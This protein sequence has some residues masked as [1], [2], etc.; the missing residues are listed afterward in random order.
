VRRYYERV[1]GLAFSGTAKDTFVL[2]SGNVMSAFFGFVFTLFVAR[3]LSVADFGVFSAATNLVIILISLTDL[4][5]STGIVNFV[6]QKRGEGDSKGVN[7][8]IKAS[9]VIKVAST[10]FL[11]LLVVAFAGFISPKFLATGDVTV[12]FWV[13]LISVSFA[14]P[15]LLPSVLQA[16]RRFLP[17]VIAD[18]LLYFSRLLFALGFMY[19]AHLTI[20]NS[21]LTFALAGIVGTIVGTLFVKPDFLIAKPGKE[22]YKNLMKFSGW[23][24]VNRV[25]S[26]ISGKLDVQMLAFFAGAIATGFYS[27]PSRLA[28][29]IIVLASSFSA[30]LAPRLASFGDSEKEKSYILKSLLAVIPISAGIVLWV[31]FAEPFIVLLFGEKYIPSVP[32]FQVLALAQIPFLFSIPATTAIIYS[33]KKTVY[34]GAYSFF[35][36]AAI[37]LLNLVFIPKFGPIGPTITFAI[38]NVI[39]AVFGWVIVYRHYWLK[40]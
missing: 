11:S 3:A 16:E 23:I 10:I 32:V 33:M 39:A 18:N 1:K 7:E 2:F 15:M 12:S 5:V 8:Y 35:Q 20:G 26:G 30:V 36:I 28:S 34:V 24:G 13:A 17:S 22:V 27:I 21:L 40:K 19:F 25:I 4:G 31:I 38:S 37:F 6:A 29:F 14:L 9:V